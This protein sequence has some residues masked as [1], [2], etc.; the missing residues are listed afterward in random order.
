VILG[1]AGRARSGKDTVAARLVERHGYVRHAFADALKE[2][3][4]AVFGLTREQLYGDD[5]ERVDPFWQDTPRRILQLFGT[6]C[7]RRGYRDDVWIKALERR[8]AG[9]PHVVIPDLR[10]PNELAAIKAWGG[11]AVLVVRPGAGATGGVEGHASES[12]LD[13]VREWDVVIENSGTLDQLHQVVDALYVRGW[14]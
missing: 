9:L 13:H 11:A 6:E 2:G 14:K 3:C 12:A 1:I 5:K 8:I 7:V 10:F 4:A